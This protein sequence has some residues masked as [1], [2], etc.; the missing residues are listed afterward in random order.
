MKYQKTL[1]FGLGVAAYAIVEVI[2]IVPFFQNF[3]EHSRTSKQ[4]IEQIKTFE[5]Y[6][7]TAYQCS[8]NKWT[9][10]YGTTVIKGK[11]VK[12]GMKIT[13]IEADSFLVRDVRAFENAVKRHVKVKLNQNQFDALVSFTYNVGVG[14]F[15]RSR[16]LRKINNNDFNG[17]AK[18][19]DKW[20]KAK[21]KDGLKVLRGLVKRRAMEKALFVTVPELNEFIDLSILKPKG[22]EILESRE[23]PVVLIGF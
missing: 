8:A 1:A 11:P 12:A 18:E 2:N 3:N 13:K 7:E 6:S 10:G 15:A 14:N 20:N 9:I 16:L 19:F 17:A 23:K 5:G 4:G 22:N 21:T